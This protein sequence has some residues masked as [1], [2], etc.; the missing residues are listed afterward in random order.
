[1]NIAQVDA[2]LQPL[3]KSIDRETFIYDLLLAYGLPKASITRLRKRN[4]N[5]SHEE[6][7]IAWKNKLLFREEFAEDLH[8]TIAELAMKVNHDQ[9]FVVVTDYEM[10]LAIDTKTQD[11]LDID[12]KD[13]PRHYDF[14]LPWA[15]MEKAQHTHENP[16]DVKAAE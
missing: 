11:K 2:N 12:L 6:G 13:L 16:A 4:L 3:I 10:L 15:G 5:L 7:T 9:R 14:F 8:S 1:M